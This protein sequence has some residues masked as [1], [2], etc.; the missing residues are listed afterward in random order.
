MCKYVIVSFEEK[1]R[2]GRREEGFNEAHGSWQMPETEAG[3][4]P[5]I[6][7]TG[8]GTCPADSGRFRQSQRLGAEERP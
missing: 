1:G 8:D 6:R 4:Y 7:P 2:G 3:T 5:R